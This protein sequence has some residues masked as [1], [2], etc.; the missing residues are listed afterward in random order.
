MNGKTKVRLHL[1]YH[2]RPAYIFPIK[3]LLF[4]IIILEIEKVAN[5]SSPYYPSSHLLII[6]TPSL[7]YRG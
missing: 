1:L 6:L 4:I 5:P 2:Y 3:P 7:R